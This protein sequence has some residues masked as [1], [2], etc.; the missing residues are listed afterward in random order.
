MKLKIVSYRVRVI[1]VEDF[2]CLCVTTHL[3]ERAVVVK[4]SIYMTNK[5]TDNLLVM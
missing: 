2:Y 4:Y 1:S 3:T 5:I